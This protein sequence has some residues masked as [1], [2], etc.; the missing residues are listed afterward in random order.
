MLFNLRLHN[1]RSYWCTVHRVLN[2][3]KESLIQSSHCVCEKVCLLVSM[4]TTQLAAL[5]SLT[6]PNYIL[7]VPGSLQSCLH[8]NISLWSSMTATLVCVSHV[9]VSVK[10]WTNGAGKLAG[11]C[12]WK[13]WCAQDIFWFLASGLR[14]QHGSF[15]VFMWHPDISSWPVAK[16]LN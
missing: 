2:L 1:K 11:V 3:Y 4:D 7:A 9:G 12:L 14:P 15:L 16:K 10:R 5:W 6:S 13:L 8:N